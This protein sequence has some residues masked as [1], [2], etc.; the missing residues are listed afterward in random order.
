MPVP[1]DGPR[2]CLEPL[3]GLVPLHQFLAW[4]FGSL[5]AWA[6]FPRVPATQAQGGPLR[7][8]GIHG[9]QYHA[10]ESEQKALSPAGGE[11]A[12]FVGRVSRPG[13]PAEPG[14]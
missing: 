2:R 14:C 4:H 9:K 13:R 3:G 6:D 7:S 1:P 12:I 5:C 10:R 8:T 11:R